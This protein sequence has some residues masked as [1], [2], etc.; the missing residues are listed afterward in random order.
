MILTLAVAHFTRWK[1]EEFDFR[2][3]N[4]GKHVQALTQ[5]GSVCLAVS[6]KNK[7]QCVQV[8]SVLAASFWLFFTWPP[9]L[10]QVLN[11]S[12]WRLEMASHSKAFK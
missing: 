2:Y 8:T 3:P 10:Y 4:V 1:N 9:T 6:K 5:R 11:S 12:C 7:P